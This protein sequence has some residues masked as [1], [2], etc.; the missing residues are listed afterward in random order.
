MTN[1]EIDRYT[2]L[3]I[4]FYGIHCE[5]AV[6]FIQHTSAVGLMRSSHSEA[7]A[8]SLCV[9]PPPKKPDRGPLCYGLLCDWTMCFWFPQMCLVDTMA[10]SSH[11]DKPPPGRPTPWRWLVSLCCWQYAN[12]LQ[13]TA[14][15]QKCFQLPFYP[16]RW[17]YSIVL[18]FGPGPRTKY[19][20]GY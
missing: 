13:K 10:L 7:V 20:F 1:H 11:M 8:S 9:V 19:I 15:P 14:G 5:A 6:L 3:F 12:L 17:G 4:H 18:R 16:I 2:W